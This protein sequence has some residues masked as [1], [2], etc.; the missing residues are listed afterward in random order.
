MLLRFQFGF[1]KPSAFIH[2]HTVN[3]VFKVCI[4]LAYLAE[5]SSNAYLNEIDL[6]IDVCTFDFDVFFTTCGDW[7][8]DLHRP[9]AH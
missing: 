3:P 2:R 9:T 8:I 5:V 7:T 4:Q 1:F 6:N